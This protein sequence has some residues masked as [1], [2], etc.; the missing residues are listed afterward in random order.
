MQISIITYFMYG[1]QK[2]AAKFFI[3]FVTIALVQL[4]SE[5]IGMLFAM[6][7]ASA[8]L[9]IILLSIVFILLLALTGFLTS[10]TPVYYEWILHLN[11]LRYERCSWYA[12]VM[13]LQL[14]PECK[15]AMW[16]VW[17]LSVTHRTGAHKPFLLL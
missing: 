17:R 7:V 4:T 16:L 15:F 9:A 6:M 5:S 8:E 13:C 2:D 11:Y 14:Q 3:Y 1:L 12:V 10:T